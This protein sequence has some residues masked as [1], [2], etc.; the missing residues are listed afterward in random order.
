MTGF[1]VMAYVPPLLGCPSPRSIS[2]STEMALPS[3]APTSACNFGMV[4]SLG[5]GVTALGTPGSPTADVPMHNMRMS[6]CSVCAV[7]TRTE[8]QGSFLGRLTGRQHLVDVGH[9]FGHCLPLP[10]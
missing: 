3:G 5:T 2:G 9:G 6:Q 7:V 10:R 4:S 8:V 1:R